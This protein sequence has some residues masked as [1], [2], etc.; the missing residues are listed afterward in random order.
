MKRPKAKLDGTRGST[1]QDGAPQLEAAEQKGD[2]LIRDLW[3]NRTDSVHNM[4]VVNTD[5][6]THALKTPKECL[7]ESERG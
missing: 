1:Y 2:L 6:K 7:Q 5:A 4:C 3:H